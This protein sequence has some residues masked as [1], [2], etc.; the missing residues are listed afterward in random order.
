MLCDV[1]EEDW[2]QKIETRCAMLTLKVLVTILNARK[3]H[4]LFFDNVEVMSQQWKGLG[5]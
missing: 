4:T 1:F 5:F 2:N 3:E